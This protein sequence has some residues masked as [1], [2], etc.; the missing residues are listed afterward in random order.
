MI[1]K[2]V[3]KVPGGK[4]LKVTVDA[5]DG[6]IG[7]VAIHGDFFCHP[8]DSIEGLERKLAGCRSTNAGNVISGYLEANDVRLYGI[9]AKSI[10][11]TI[12]EAAGEVQADRVGIQ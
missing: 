1:R 5:Q 12:M 10:T 7:S 4:L 11:E 2:C 6:M 9:D 3:R 8:E